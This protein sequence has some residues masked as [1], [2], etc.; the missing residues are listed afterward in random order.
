MESS[1]AES[2]TF[3][4]Q[5]QAWSILKGREKEELDKTQALSWRHYLS[6]VFDK[7]LWR[8]ALKIYNGQV[9]NLHAFWQTTTQNKNEL[10]FDH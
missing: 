4:E 7:W 2:R 5:D 9:Y 6:G 1:S 10:H 3:R 8:I